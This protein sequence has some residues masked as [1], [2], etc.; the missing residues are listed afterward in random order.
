[1]AVKLDKLF[2]EPVSLNIQALTYIANYKTDIDLWINS[3]AELELGEAAKQIFITLLEL[4][5]F[6]CSD[7]VRFQI[8][9]HLEPQLAHL[10][11]SLEQHYL[12]NTL[13]DTKRDQQIS[14]L[15]LE[16]KSHH[17]LLYNEILARTEQ[18]LTQHNFSLFEF[19]LKKK[20]T[21]LRKQA[22]FLS[23]ERLTNL[24]YSLQILYYDVPQ[25]FWALSYTAYKNALTHQYYTER[26]DTVLDTESTVDTVQ[27]SFCRLLLLYLLNNHKLRQSEIKELMQCIGYWT[28]L[29]QLFEHP[30]AHSTYYC[31][32]ATDHPPHFYFSHMSVQSQAIYIDLSALCTY[33]ESTLKPNAHY[34][35]KQEQKL[36]TQV[37]KHHIIN[38]LTLDPSGISPRYN[39][40]G[41]FEIA[42]GMTSAHFF[43]SHAKHFK[44]TL[45]LDSD[46][47]IKNNLQSLNHLNN[48]T[49]AQLSARRYEQRFNAE[50]TKIYQVNLINRSDSGYGLQWQ[51]KMVKNFRTGEFVLLKE[52]Q[53][54]EWTGAIIRWMKNSNE[55]AIDFG[56]EKV[57]E[58]MCPIA[59]CLPNQN[60]PQ[61]VYHP[62]I[63]YRNPK[64]QFALVLPSAQI[65]YEEQSLI[66]RFAYT[67]LRI[68]L[69]QSHILMQNCAT[70]DFELLEQSKLTLLQQHFEQHLTALKTQDLWESLK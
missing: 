14:D 35:S 9:Q 2:N 43:L 6:D 29:V 3:L 1:M 16:I 32:T 47:A 44:E 50:I 25:N 59:V 61:P 17:A 4:R 40:Q 49:T 62:A 53:Q 41:T 64:Q 68:Y 26:I 55:Q 21:K 69:K 58:Q 57:A 67:E 5:S 63:L 15:V 11:R 34:Y 45:A 8:I 30:Q 19:N 23:L 33:I 51:N 10:L 28:A 27:K 7:L 36:L 56:V 24:L 37:L 60:T 20:L 31:D 39:E 52:H 13:L 46:I 22:S 12:N 38:I 42:L 70:F 54:D 65:F 66:L 18:T 48:E